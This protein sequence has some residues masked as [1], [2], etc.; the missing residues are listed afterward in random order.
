MKMSFHHS[1]QA[2]NVQPAQEPRQLN[3]VQLEFVITSFK[4]QA[5]VN[6]R[7]LSQQEA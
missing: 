2:W 1:A 3:P 7:K 4:A 5:L 6:A